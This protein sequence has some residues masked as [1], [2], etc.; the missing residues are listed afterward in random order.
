MSLRT[1]FILFA[2]VIHVLLAVMAYFLLKENVFLFL[3]M[4]LL[5]LGSI[6]ITAQLYSTFFKPLSLIRAGIQSIK[7]KDFS[8]KFMGVGQ[9]ELD[10]LI[11]VYNRMIDQLRHERV[12]QAEKHYFL[13]KLIQASPTGILLLGFDNQVEHVNPAAELYLQQPASSLLGKHVSQLP[14]VWAEQLTHLQNGSSITF[15]VNG[16]RTYRCQRAH[17]LDR[18]FQHYFVLIEELTEAILQ[19]ERQ[20]YEKVIR[21]MS[22]EVNN[23]A[24][25]VNSILGSLQYYA[26][27]LTNDH[28]EDFDNAL[29]VAI[30]RNT[31]LSRFMANFANVVRL[32]KPKKTPTNLH[33]LLR[34][35]VLLMQPEFQR[36]TIGC[37]LQL[38]SQPLI[39]LLD[40]QQMEQVLLN[41]LKNAIEAIEE[42]GEI[43][44]ATQTNP[45]QLTITD[46]GS[47]ISESVRSSLFTPF[48]STKEYGQGIG[49]T[50]IREILVNH[51]F[52]FSLE[53]DQE[54]GVTIFS[55]R[56]SG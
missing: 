37:T 34:N 21:M 56:F 24:G 47:G 26:P 51:G 4:E 12:A 25:A 46:T 36:R 10:E 33:T 38:A 29:Q 44:I 32:P 14:K 30:D 23:S 55:V 11:N 42:G 41:V 8:T 31:N 7:D 20:A 5:I 45:A 16:I 28:R 52:T 43:T 17:F 2:T 39:I 50:M 48:F 35:M 1:K 15:R 53:S 22:H 40:Q 54:K 9:K 18:G 27:Q 3:G 13:E 6:Y 49:L 19:N